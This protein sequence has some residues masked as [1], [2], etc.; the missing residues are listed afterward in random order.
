L[1]EIEDQE[2][3]HTEEADIQK[4]SCNQAWHQPK[5]ILEE[6]KRSHCVLLRRFPLGLVDY[7]PNPL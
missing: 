3:N 5:P 7:E 1:H 2:T 4:V 6:E